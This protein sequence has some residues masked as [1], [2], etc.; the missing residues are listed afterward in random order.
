[1]L[2]LPAPRVAT[3]RSYIPPLLHWTDIRNCI[4]AWRQIRRGWPLLDLAV[5]KGRSDAADGEVA[6]TKLRLYERKKPSS[7]SAAKS[8][9]AILRKVVSQTWG[10]GFLAEAG[11]E[12]RMDA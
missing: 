2:A 5:V 4:G 7:V 12:A 11:G 1:M 10:R 9:R 6:V 3:S 8:K